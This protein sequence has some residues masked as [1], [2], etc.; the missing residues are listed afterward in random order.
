[1]KRL[2]QAAMEAVDSGI[3]KNDIFFDITETSSPYVE[4][5]V[6]NVYSPYGPREG[7]IAV[8]PYYSYENIFRYV[9]QPGKVPEV[10]RFLCD[11]ILHH[12]W[13]VDAFS[14]MDL[15]AFY[16]RFMEEDI[17]SG[18]FGSEVSLEDF[19]AKEIRL[20]AFYYLR[21]CR[22]GNYESCFCHILRSFY[23]HAW[24]NAREDGSIVVIMNTES[25]PENERR[26]KSIQNLFLQAGRKC[27][28]YWDIPPGIIECEETTIGNF[29]L[30]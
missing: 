20:A 6:K 16:I 13:E 23:K 7:L 1:M 2:W 24:V 26:V 22:T 5:T 19:T 11:L 4:A 17:L 8:N 9:I 29:V 15:E 10:T 21:L 12:L 28:L 3:R 27:R 18:A 30:F 25:S 14:G